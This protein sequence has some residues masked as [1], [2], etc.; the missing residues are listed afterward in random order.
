MPDIQFVDPSNGLI[1]FDSHIVESIMSYPLEEDENT[2]NNLL[3]AMNVINTVEVVS[4]LDPAACAWTAN[5]LQLR[6][7]PNKIGI[8]V[9]DGSWFSVSGA[10]LDSLVHSPPIETQIGHSNKN[11][12]RGV[13]AGEL[14]LAV[15][16]DWDGVD[17]PPSLSKTT[18]VYE[19]YLKK[20]QYEKRQKGVF[21]S[22][23]VIKYDWATYRSVAHLWAAEVLWRNDFRGNN[24]YSRKHPDGL[25]VYLAVAERLRLRGEQFRPRHSKNKILDSGETWKCPPSLTLPEIEICLGRLSD[26]ARGI[27]KRPKDM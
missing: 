13:N 26:W 27:L 15:L 9:D 7:L 19:E 21:S 22:P 8:P 5:S 23:R 18:I 11:T 24:Q 14:F 16:S 2:R 3:A 20:R 17:V 6:P 25:A 12:Q 4:K 1:Q 10:V